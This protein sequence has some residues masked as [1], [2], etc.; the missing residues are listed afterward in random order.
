MD[1]MVNSISGIDL[2]RPD[3]IQTSRP[4]LDSQGPLQQAA[5]SRPSASPELA[6]Q[7]KA[8]NV[9]RQQAAIPEISLR[10]RVDA[11]TQEV[12]LLILDKNTRELI[13]S[14]PPEEMKNIGPG[15]LL[16]LFT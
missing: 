4:A 8:E 14:I 5:P 13:R 15:E 3:P 16:E 12:T 10:F 1:Q 9:S 7:D 6:P 2:H 11:E